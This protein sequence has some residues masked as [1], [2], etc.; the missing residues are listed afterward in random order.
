[1]NIDQRQYI[2]NERC[3]GYSE[4]IRICASEEEKNN[5]V[6]AFIM[7]LSALTSV[8]ELLF[9]EEEF[10]GRLDIDIA[11]DDNTSEDENL[12]TAPRWAKIGDI[13]FFAYGKRAIAKI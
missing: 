6:Q 5:N 1:M 13:I 2:N 11:I 12:W 3:I 10:D 7:N 4:Q 8:E 9:C